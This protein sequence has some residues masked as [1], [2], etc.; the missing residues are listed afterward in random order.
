MLNYSSKDLN[1]K[2]P[3]MPELHVFI[4]EKLHSLKLEETDTLID[5]L[6]DLN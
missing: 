1:N 3:D 5:I 2:K 4:E 6:K